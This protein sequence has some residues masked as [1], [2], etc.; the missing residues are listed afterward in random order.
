MS[1]APQGCQIRPAGMVD[2]ER[3]S[4]GCARQRAGVVG[5]LCPAAYCLQA[6]FANMADL[7][8]SKLRS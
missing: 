7:L 4:T 5:V 2:P 8:H 1:E 6:S 3:L